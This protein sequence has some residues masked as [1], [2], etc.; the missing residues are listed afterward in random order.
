VTRSLLILF[1]STELSC[2]VWCVL[3]N[4]YI[5][6]QWY[7]FVFFTDLPTSANFDKFQ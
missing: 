5:R 3:Y 1:L 4:N 2:S 6:S 7:S